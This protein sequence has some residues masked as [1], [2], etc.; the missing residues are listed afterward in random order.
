M[1]NDALNF[2]DLHVHSNYSDGAFPPEKLIRLASDAALAAIAIADHDSVAGVNEGISA[3]MLENIEVIPAVELSVQFKAWEDVHLLGYGID[4]ADCQFLK[5]L[6]GFRDRRENRNIDILERVNEM[7]ISEH[8]DPIDLAEVLSFTRDAIGRPHIAR[9]LLERGY[10]GNV[11]DAFR[12]YLV[13]CNVPKC[14]WPID[15]AIKEIRRI[16]GIAILAHPTSVSA[17]RQEL[18]TIIGELSEIGL[19][20]IEVFNNMAKEDEMEYL[21]R[22]ALESG[23]LITGGSD[24]HGIEEGLEMGKGRGGI[25]FSS[26][27][28][29]PLRKRLTVRRNQLLSL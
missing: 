12:R 23:L 22:F 10:A 11:E 26:S 2:I 14:Y 20:G 8:R 9:A 28:L 13:P 3:G 15:D 6:N 25:R 19:D 17:E 4:V 24:F 29:A 27:L 21:R 16:G 7:L 1:K 5:K 18:L